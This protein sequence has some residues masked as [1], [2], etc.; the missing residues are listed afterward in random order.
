LTTGPEGEARLERDAQWHG[1][2][3]IVKVAPN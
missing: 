1:R 3:L 2:Q